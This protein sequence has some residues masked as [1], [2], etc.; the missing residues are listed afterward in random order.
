VLYEYGDSDINIFEGF[1]AETD[2]CDFSEVPFFQQKLKKR[3]SYCNTVD[4][5]S[6]QTRVSPLIQA[7]ISL[8]RPTMLRET[9]IL[10]QIRWKRLVVDE[11]HVTVAAN[12]L[13]Y[14]CSN[15]NVERRWIVTGTPT[16]NLMGLSL[17]QSIHSPTPDG[18]APDDFSQETA[19]PTPVAPEI[20][21]D[22]ELEYPGCYSANI[23]PQADSEDLRRF[24]LMLSRFLRVPQFVGEV[25]SKTFLDSVISPVM[26][27]EGPRFGSIQLLTQVMSSVMFR[28][29]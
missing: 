28:H 3:E 20:D 19:S 11:G 9:K 27:R 2:R 13:A 5:S 10:H 14:L 29:R 21:E 6:D 8:Y 12:K 22:S 1:S 25:N 23:W 7:C 26:D 18:E 17:G 16:R 15:L 4:D 24:R